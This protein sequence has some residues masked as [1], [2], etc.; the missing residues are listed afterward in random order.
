M[1]TLLVLARNDTIEAMR[2]A[3]GL[4]IF[5]HSVDLVLL[6]DTVKI[7]A[8]NEQLEI[9]ELAE[10]EPLTVLDS[11]PEQFQKISAS[12]LKQFMWDAD[13]VLNF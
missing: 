13:A 5:G 12:D 9:L 4:T 3:A 1:K 2:V 7:E 10:I 11:L 6:D 8:D